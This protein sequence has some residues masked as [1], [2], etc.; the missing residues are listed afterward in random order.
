MLKNKTYILPDNL[1]LKIYSV[2]RIAC[3][4]TISSERRS[5]RTCSAAVLLMFFREL[6]LQSMD[7]RNE[8]KSKNYPFCHQA[9]WHQPAQL[10]TQTGSTLDTRTNHDYS[11][12]GA[13]TVILVQCIDSP[14]SL[15]GPATAALSVTEW[16]H[17]A[18]EHAYT[19]THKNQ[20]CKVHM[21]ELRSCWLKWTPYLLHAAQ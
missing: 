1:V 8:Q 9:L 5:V 13:M 6:A 3:K 12:T 18:L 16:L 4:C 7:H 14:F 2:E 10:Q 21:K 20:P 15:T 11:W 17:P 19:H